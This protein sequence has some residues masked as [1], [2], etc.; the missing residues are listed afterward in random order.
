M[1]DD[2]RKPERINIDHILN[3]TG[4]DA[5]EEEVIEIVDASETEEA[6]SVVEVA[7]GREREETEDPGASA[8]E[9]LLH[10][11]LREKEE[12]QDQCMRALADLDNYRKRVEREREEQRLRISMDLVREILPAMDDLGRALSQPADAPGFR[13]GIALIQKQ[14]DEALRRL[15]IEPIDALGESFDPVY[16]EALSAEPREGFEPN[17]IIE[18]IRRGY[19]LGGRVVRPSLVKVVIAAPLE[20]SGNTGESGEADGT[21]HRD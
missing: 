20:R 2:K 8:V 18:E 7:E 12:L 14:F 4:G 16:H 1:P 5:G 3:E 13:E 17:T 15:G 9:D 19:T 10:E 21:G 6:E 11:A